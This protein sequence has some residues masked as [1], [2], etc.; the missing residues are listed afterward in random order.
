[1][2]LNAASEGNIETRSPD[3][4]RMLIENLVFSNSTKNA[5]VDKMKSTGNMDSGQIA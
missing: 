5:D 2:V 3:K 4:V 1:M